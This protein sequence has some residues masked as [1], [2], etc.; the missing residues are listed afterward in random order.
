VAPN[1]PGIRGCPL[2]PAQFSSSGDGSSTWIMG[3]G[4]P[5]AESANSVGAAKIVV[6][7]SPVCKI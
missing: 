6:F 1:T 7:G 4:I 2:G 5:A 3:S